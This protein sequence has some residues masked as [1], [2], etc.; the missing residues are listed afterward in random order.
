M[1]T[2]EKIKEKERR[3]TKPVEANRDSQQQE[4]H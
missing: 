1:N 2:A 4:H 3:R